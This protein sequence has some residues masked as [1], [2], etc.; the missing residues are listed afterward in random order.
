MPTPSDIG[1]KTTPLS[2]RVKSLRLPKQEPAPGGGSWWRWALA[3]AVLGAFLYGGHW[4]TSWWENPTPITAGGGVDAES[5]STSVSRTTASPVATRRPSSAAPTGAASRS[6][7]YSLQQDGYVVP[8][9]QILVSPKIAG[10]ITRLYVEEGMRVQKGDLLAE[11]E[12]TDYEADLRRAKAELAAA[13]HRLLELTNGSRNEEID[14]ARSELEE[15]QAQRDQ[16]R[17]E[18]A[19]RK[20][21]HTERVLSDTDYELAESAYHAIVHRIGKLKANLA[22]LKEGPRHERIDLARADVEAS[23]ADVMKAQWRLDNC[24]I[25]APISGTILRKNAEEGNIVNPIAFNGSYSVCDIADLSDLEIDLTIQ[26]RDL[27]QIT[28]GQRCEIESRAFPDRKYQGYV[29]RLMPVADRSKQSVAVRVKVEIPSEEEGVYLKPDMT[30]RVSFL[31]SPSGSESGQPRM[32]ERAAARP[33][34]IGASAPRGAQSSV[35]SAQSDDADDV[36]GNELLENE[37]IEDATDG[38]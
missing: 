4:L 38:G 23:K 14:A 19:R 32:E 29:S 9:R 27:H 2:E 12:S 8:R 30:A 24:R 20:Q 33:G 16:L 37:M 36:S 3:V 17:S 28:V 10:M 18:W 21:L 13:K 1:A 34:S 6:D 5:K 35:K 11:L 7:V 26:E 15:A 25:V 31:R 22:L